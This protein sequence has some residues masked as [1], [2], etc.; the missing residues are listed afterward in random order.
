[1]GGLFGEEEERLAGFVA[2]LVGTALENAKSYA[3]LEGAFVA[4]NDAHRELK[5]T[6]AQLS[7]RPSSPP[8]DSS[9]RASLTS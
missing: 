4:L 3:E 8:W 2:S 6:Q 1:V 9:A 7:R 5:S